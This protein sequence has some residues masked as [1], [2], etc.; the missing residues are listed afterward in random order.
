[1]VWTSIREWSYPSPIIDI[2]GLFALPLVLHPNWR[3]HCPPK[4]AYEM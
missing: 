3:T 1:M 4:R 2:V